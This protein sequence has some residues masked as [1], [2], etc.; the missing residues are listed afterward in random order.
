MAAD[1]NLVYESATDVL[2]LVQSSSWG[3]IRQIP[4]EYQNPIL[5]ALIVASRALDAAATAATEQDESATGSLGDKIGRLRR[6]VGVL[7]GLNDDDIPPA[8]RDAFGG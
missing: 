8:F 3:M 4:P 6:E 2:T 5:V 7:A 1:G